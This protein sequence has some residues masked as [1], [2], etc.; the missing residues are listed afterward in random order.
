VLKY[1]LYRN[2]RAG[3][4]LLILLVV[5]LWLEARSAHSHG[6]APILERAVIAAYVPIQ[7]LDRSVDG[8]ARRWFG[9]RR[10]YDQARLENESMKLELMELEVEKALLKD[11]VLELEDEAELPD[12]EELERIPARVIYTEPMG[13]IILNDPQYIERLNRLPSQE[14]YLGN[15]LEARRNQLYN[16]HTAVIIDAGANKGV[17]E[18][19]LVISADGVIGR[20]SLVDANWSK[21]RLISHEQCAFGAMDAD[22]GARGVFRLGADGR[23]RLDYISI[24]LSPQVSSPV[25]TSGEGGIIPR[26]FLLGTIEEVT[27]PRDRLTKEIIVR[28]AAKLGSLS[29]V[30]IVRQRE[31][32]FEGE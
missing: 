29:T 24:D 13:R 15:D 6:R 23:Y 27:S 8:L 7:A 19:D 21:V 1:L 25:I 14:S 4:A 2:R 3:A 16:L 22:S 5:A 20:V 17:R 11:R 12:R 26:G 10:D 9:I 31:V 18:Y 28:P 30:M 32:L